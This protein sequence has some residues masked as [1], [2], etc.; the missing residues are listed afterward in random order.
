MN[1]FFSSTEFDGLIWTEKGNVR[2]AKVVVSINYF[3]V[4]SLAHAYQSQTFQHNDMDGPGDYLIHVYEK[5]EK[6]FGSGK[7]KIK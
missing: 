2:D 7:F 1:F 5:G 3:F 6:A 4:Y